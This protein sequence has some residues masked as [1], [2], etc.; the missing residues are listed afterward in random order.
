[1]LN[2]LMCQFACL[3]DFSLLCSLVKLSY[4]LAKLLLGIVAVFVVTQCCR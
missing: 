3:G 1:L 2:P 4:F